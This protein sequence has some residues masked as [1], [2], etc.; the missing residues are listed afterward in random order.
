MATDMI[1]SQIISSQVKRQSAD[2]HTGDRSVVFLDILKAGIGG[3][4]HLITD[5]FNEVN[6]SRSRLG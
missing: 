5:G 1:S 2:K 3:V 4:V 6:I